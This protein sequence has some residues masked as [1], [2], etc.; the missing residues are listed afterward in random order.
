FFKIAKRGKY[1]ID[2]KKMKDEDAAKVSK[3]YKKMDKARKKIRREM[4]DEILISSYLGKAGRCIEPITRF[5]G[6]NWRVNI[7]LLSSFAAKENSVATLGSI[8]QAEP[9]DGG[10][11]LEDRMKGKE[12]G[13]T[14]LHALALILFMAM[15]PPCIPTL[16][17]IKVETGSIKW[18][19]FAAVYPI[20]LGIGISVLVFT[21]GR[22]LGLSGLQAM[23]AFYILALEVTLITACIKGKTELVY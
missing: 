13:W 2:D 6:F 15:Y 12:K 8:Y 9:D 20:V 23:V 3:I 10:I 4:R 17:M 7:A 11:R 16:L 19:L 1:E 18:A 5:S 21:G 14:P 22:L